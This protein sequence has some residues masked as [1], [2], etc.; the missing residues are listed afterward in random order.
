MAL[1]NS[2][3]VLVENIHM[4]ASP[5]WVRFNRPDL[6]SQKTNIFRQHNFV[7][8]SSYVEYSKRRPSYEV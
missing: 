1:I 3:N 4:I 6:I 8:G 5:F 7:V 2:T